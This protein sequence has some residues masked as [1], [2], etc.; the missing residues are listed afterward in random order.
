MPQ[1]CREDIGGER[2]PRGYPPAKEDSR[3]LTQHQLAREQVYVTLGLGWKLEICSN[4]K[5]ES[6]P[7]R[8]YREI[9]FQLLII[10]SNLIASCPDFASPLL[11]ARNRLHWDVKMHWWQITCLLV[12]I[13]TPL[14]EGNAIWEIFLASEKLT[15]YRNGSFKHGICFFT[16]VELIRLW[17]IDKRQ[18]VFWEWMKNINRHKSRKCASILFWLMP[19]L[20]W[21]HK[22]HDAKSLQ[23]T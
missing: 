12:N 11:V 19:P 4:S 20:V 10:K 3:R 8:T 7:Y 21:I 15:L 13:L 6:E 9:G 14:I 23:N 2:I 18:P 5:V 16:Y 17:F 1:C 22:L